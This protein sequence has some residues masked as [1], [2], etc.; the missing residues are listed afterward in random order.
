MIKLIYDIY[1]MDIKVLLLFVI[2]CINTVLFALNLGKP[3]PVNEPGAQFN[4][5]MAMVYVVFFAFINPLVEGFVY[6]VYVVLSSFVCAVMKKE[7]ERIGRSIAS[8]IFIIPGVITALS[9]LMS[10]LT[11]TVVIKPEINDPDA[12]IQM[13]SVFKDVRA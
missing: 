1:K 6:L 4:L 2:P 8:F 9:M 5:E 11:P 3:D 12:N 7:N 13:V 10:L